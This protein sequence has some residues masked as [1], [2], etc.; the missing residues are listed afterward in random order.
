M[1][2]AREGARPGA[3]QLARRAMT[4]QVAEMAI[5]LFVDRGYEETTIDDICAVAGISR[6]SFFRY[7]HSKEDVLLREV[8][9][10]GESLLAALQAR[11]DDETPWV[12]L[13]R[14][15]NPLIG[16]YGAESERILRSARLVR[17]TPALATFHQEKLARGAGLLDLAEERARHHDVGEVRLYTNEA[18]TE[19]LAYYPRHGYTE[20]HRASQDGF[21]R[22][23]FRKTIVHLSRYRARRGTRSSE[24]RDRVRL[25]GPPRY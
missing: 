16:Q 23:F 21:R 24:V 17:A 20:T 19:N 9:D 13:R 2:A 6:S 25:S 12:A 11:P 15:L 7:F 8:A 5:D 18:M 22:V 10:L 14:A 4:A 3:R 1:S